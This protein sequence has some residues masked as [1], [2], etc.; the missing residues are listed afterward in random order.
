MEYT[1]KQAATASLPNPVRHLEIKYSI[2]IKCRKPS[3]GYTA[4]DFS[5]S[6]QLL[7]VSDLTRLLFYRRLKP[8][9][10]DISRTILPIVPAPDDD[11]DDDDDV[12]GAVGRISGKVIE[13]TR[14]YQPQCRFV[15]YKSNVT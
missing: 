5:N 15:Y 4:G 11:D 13:C 14:E 7:K 3:S 8:S 6:A 1:T 10:L 9:P 12:C 2:R